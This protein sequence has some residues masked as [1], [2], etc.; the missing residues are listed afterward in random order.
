MAVLG[1]DLGGRLGHRLRRKFVENRVGLQLMLDVQVELLRVILENLQRL[2]H[3]LSQHQ[4][5]ALRLDQPYIHAHHDVRDPFPSRL[6]A[7]IR[8][9]PAS[10]QLI[11]PIYADILSESWTSGNAIAPP[12][13]APQGPA[14]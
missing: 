2:L 12:E 13:R 6:Y 7:I 9:A 4:T 10:C 3:L 1:V 5:L 8:P 11:A 14:L